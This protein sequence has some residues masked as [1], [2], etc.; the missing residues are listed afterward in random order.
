M[1]I[2]N[3]KGD[4]STQPRQIVHAR[5]SL[6]VSNKDKNNC[7]DVP[8]GAMGFKDGE[9]TP[10]LQK[11]KRRSEQENVTCRQW[12]GI[13]QVVRRQQMFECSQQTGTILCTENPIGRKAIQSR[14]VE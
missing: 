1:G 3:A 2:G 14:I 12:V 11:A 7:H 6:V 4:V 13:R 8:P 9:S 5:Q 10:R